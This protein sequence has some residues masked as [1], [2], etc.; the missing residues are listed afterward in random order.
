MVGWLRQ[1]LLVLVSGRGRDS[2]ELARRLGRPSLRLDRHSAHIAKAGSDD[3]P[4]SLKYRWHRIPKR[5]GGTR[6]L[7]SPNPALKKVQRQLLRRVFGK[8]KVHPAAHGFQRGRSIVTHARSHVGQAVVVRVDIEDFFPRTQGDRIFRYFRRIGWNRG[9][10]SLLLRLCTKR[11]GASVGLPQGAPTSPILSNLVN[12]GMDARLAGL[13]RRSNARYSRYADD[14]IFSFSSDD[15]RFIRGVIRRVRRILNDSGYRMHGRAKL[16]VLR[17]HQ[18]QIVTGLVVNEKVQL[19][20]R[21]RRWLRAVEHHLKTGRRASLSRS[22]L[23]GWRALEKMI[24]T[25]SSAGES[26]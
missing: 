23:A 21:T 2:A 7:H 12:Y 5:S 9:A 26:S 22:Q 24:E 16:R 13:A 8:L 1:K 11:L 18:R 25:Q 14:I 10:S 17:R 15:R 20:R 19:P 6:L 4:I 3:E